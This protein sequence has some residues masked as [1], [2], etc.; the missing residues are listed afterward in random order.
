M[1]HTSVKV[2]AIRRLNYWGASAWIFDDQL[3]ITYSTFVRYWRN[4]IVNTVELD[5]S[6]LQTLRKPMIQLEGK[7][8]TIFSLNSVYQLKQLSLLICV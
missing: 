3:L 6:Y 5:I 7:Y 1:Q 2:N 4:K 8:Y